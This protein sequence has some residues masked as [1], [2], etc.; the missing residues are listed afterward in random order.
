MLLVVVLLVRVCCAVEC[1]SFTSLVCVLAD[2]VQTAVHELT[3]VCACVVCADTSADYLA[4]FCDS[5]MHFTRYT[6]LQ[7]RAT[8]RFGD[9]HGLND[10]VCS[11]AFDR[12]DEFFATAGVSRRLK[13][14][15]FKRCVWE[16][17]S[18]GKA[19][20]RES[21]LLLSL[22]VTSAD[23]CVCFA[24]V[25]WHPARRSTFLCWSWTR[26]ASCRACAGTP[27][28]RAALP[29]Q[30]TTAPY[31]CGT[32]QPSRYA[33]LLPPSTTLLSVGVSTLAS[34]YLICNSAAAQ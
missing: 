10:M 25:C 14:F 21:A 11:I 29:P 16:S 34:S 30:T 19:H 6:E 1:S 28:S 27:T 2:A 15:D 8:L 32:L 26:A 13:V 4:T 7:E 5:L 33:I 23:V 24:A 20:L 12:D 17:A 3:D 22:V 9:M 31:S 18:V